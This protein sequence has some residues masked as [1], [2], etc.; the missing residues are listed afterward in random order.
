MIVTLIVGILLVSIFCLWEWKGARLPIVPSEH[1]DGSSAVRTLTG[2][3]VYIFKHTTVSGVYITMFVKCVPR[4]VHFDNSLYH[5]H[6]PADSFLIPL[7]IISLSFSKLHLVILHSAL[8]S[9]SCL[10]SLAKHSRV[11]LQYSPLSQS[12]YCLIHELISFLRAWRCPAQE[13]TE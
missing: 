9:S 12:V 8:E 4:P 5:L 1:T 6:L 10:Y 13:N 3:T 2:P 11:L 7:C